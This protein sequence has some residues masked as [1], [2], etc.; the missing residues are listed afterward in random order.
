MTSLAEQ[1]GALMNE[2]GR[3]QVFVIVGG[4]EV[5][6]AMR[7]LHRQRPEIDHRWMHWECV[8]LLDTTFAIAAQL[9]PAWQAVASSVELEAV[10]DQD[11]SG[12][13]L[14]RVGSYY[15][16]DAMGR[17]PIEMR[18]AESWDTTTD[19]LG[20]YLGWCVDAKEIWLLKSCPWRDEALLTQEQLEKLAEEGVVDRELPR[21]VAQTPRLG[22]RI[23]SVVASSE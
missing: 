10:L 17:V 1:V 12:I 15:N 9:N 4:G 20:W 13:Y 7:P 22:I 6:E 21:L 11:V 8:R 23:Q 16:P 3:A 14:V 2:I 19:A 18:P 5:V